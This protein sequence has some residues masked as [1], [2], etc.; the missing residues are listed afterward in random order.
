MFRTL[1]AFLHRLFRR[2][3]QN[4]SATEK[5]RELESL[6]QPQ[7][8]DVSSSVPFS[9]EL[10]TVQTDIGYFVDLQAENVSE[11]IVLPLEK[12]QLS[13]EEFVQLIL[14]KAKEIKPEAVFDYDPKDYALKSRSSEQQVLY[15]HN[16]FLEY[17][18][19]NLEERP[20]VLKKWLR[21]L[22]FLKPMPDEFEDVE[23][24][25]MPALRTRGY[26]ELTQL[27]FREQGRSM[28]TFPYQDVGERFGLTV[29]YDMH[30]SIV[31]ISQK[32][33]EEWNLS[34]Y[35]AMEI[36][37]RNLL[38]KGFTLTCLKLEDR[39]VVYIP[40]V[41]DSF[42]GTRLMLIDQIRNLEVI[43]ETV[44]LLLSTDT[45]MITGS[46]DHLGL[47]FFLSQATE[48]QENPHA[49]PPTLLKLEGD[50]WVQWLPPMESEYYL[51]FKRFQIV[52]EGTDYA[53][54]GTILRNLFQKEERNI[55]VAH[56]YVAQQETTQQLF[57]YTIWTDEEKDTLLP[58]AE[59]IAFTIQGSNTPVLIP[60]DVV[61]DTVG[62]LMDLKYEYPPRYQVGV[63][64]TT[65]ELA[66]MQR[67]SE[68]KGPFQTG[69]A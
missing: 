12:P 48:F 56:Y 67:R 39:M 42:D 35:E 9:P 64:P 28:P 63:F 6:L 37:M 50:E 52:A 49:I 5:L 7:T 54:Q 10:Q 44:A 23:P 24:D 16:A 31:M 41:G 51:P 30:D 26:F 8:I 14:E 11:Q 33:L 17:N 68:G 53:E 36:A 66:E 21:H 32:H 47:G 60:W 40:T 19:C 4:P 61:C 22:L 29:A 45:M 57:S 1:T 15:L 55:A 62:Y 20:Y 18:R 59:F 65:R 34:F 13:R 46:E 25:L 2:P 58:K 3:A 69:S 43:G 38:E 27:R